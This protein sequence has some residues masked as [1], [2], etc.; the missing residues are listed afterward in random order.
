MMKKVLCALMGA[1][2]MLMASAFAV[3]ID[4]D[5]L[6][7]GLSVLDGLF[8]IGVGLVLL[9]ILVL[10]IA[11][12]KPV[13]HEEEE[14]D[15]AA[16]FLEAI[17]PQEED[18]EAFTEN[19][20]EP[21]E[22]EITESPEELP[23]EEAEAE[24]ES[25]EELE[26]EP[27]ESEAEEEIDREPEEEKVYPTLTFTGLNNGEFKILPLKESV[28]LGRRLENDLIF[29]DT[30]I[31]GVHCEITVE[32]DKIYLEDRDS[33]NGTFLNGTRI[34]EKTEIHK[35]DILAL[36]QMELRIGI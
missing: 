1:M 13:K 16:E 21:V 15:G 6:G 18:A 14:E 12:F 20:T 22:E 24:E 8:L 31:S 29:S 32:E 28:T 36:G 35:G 10:C 17:A 33:T 2:P 4:L 3:T 23:E 7:G 27:Q 25:E 30:T 9:G 5:L 19:E 11:F 34:T 26:E